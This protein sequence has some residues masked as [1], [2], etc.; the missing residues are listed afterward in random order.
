MFKRR[1]LGVIC[2][3]NTSL[4]SNKNIFMFLTR[5]EAVLLDT[6]R[7]NL[8]KWRIEGG[9]GNEKYYHFSCLSNFISGLPMGL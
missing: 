6:A 4:G 8:L 9:G 2:A 7:Q 5:A 3:E 1:Q